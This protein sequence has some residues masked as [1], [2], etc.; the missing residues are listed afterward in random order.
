MKAYRHLKPTVIILTP[1]YNEA[2]SLPHYE[3]AVSDVLLPRED[4]CFR[5]L[6]IDDG[7]SDDSWSI[8]N[9]ICAR[10]ARFS[11]IRLSR[12]FG[13]HAALSAGFAHARGDAVA[14]LACDLQDPPQTILS[15]V[16]KWR[17]GAQIVWG[18]RKTRKDIFW[19]RAASSLFFRLLQ[20][21]AMP[22]DSKFTT[23]SFFLV[24][25]K[26]AECF[27]R[28]GETN[29]ITFALVAW[30]GFDQQ[31]V[32]YDRR[33]R[34]AGVTGWTFS[35]MLKAM[36][37]AFVGFS[38]L[39]I[40]L[41]TLMGVL[42]FAFT[43]AFS[44][45]LV[46]RWLTGSPLYGWTSIMVAMTFFFGLQFLLMGISGEYLQRIYRE[47]VRRPLYFIS[48]RTAADGEHHDAG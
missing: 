24:D 43:L 14:T 29:R 47:A 32:D 16:E 12:N 22:P 38:Y 19:R 39:P 36:Y 17:E 23:G 7:S 41:M 18:R 6:F 4:V 34:M 2:Q 40:R 21:F 37:D 35:A 44:G 28:F 33:A 45:Y 46:F 5:I 3:R 48:D 1:V 42:M 9:T 10:D 25:Q 11:G 31:V 27:Q 30:T 15:F 26:V 13:S 20:R 8:I